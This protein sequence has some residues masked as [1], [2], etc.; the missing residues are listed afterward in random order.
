[1]VVTG[2]THVFLVAFIHTPVVRAF[3]IV[4]SYAKKRYGF[5]LFIVVCNKLDE[6]SVHPAP[7]K[8]LN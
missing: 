1:M 7:Y 8:G 3:I 2:R 6:V 4:A 5:L